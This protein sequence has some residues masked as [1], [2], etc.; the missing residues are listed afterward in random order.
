M[1]PKD[2][3]FFR[4]FMDDLKTI[5]IF[6]TIKSYSKGLTYYDLQQFGNIPHSKI[7]R[8]MKSL[9]EK[10]DLIKKDAI[11][12]ETGRP[13][14]LYFLSPQGEIRLENLR[15]KLGE[16]FEFVKLRFPKEAPTFDHDAFL[17]EG[18]FKIWANPV[19]FIMRKN[20]PDSK[21]LKDL[22]DMEKDVTNILRRIRKEKKKIK[23]KLQII[24]EE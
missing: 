4:E 13:K 10:G 1:W 22:L 14:H 18:T 3:K 24:K 23:V 16:I 20:V 8:M 21:K 2:F 6:N 9:E 17:R 7:Y 5:F 15:K 19:E 12:N 11:S